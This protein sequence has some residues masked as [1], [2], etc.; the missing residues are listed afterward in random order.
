MHVVVVNVH[1]KPEAVDAFIAATADNHSHTRKEPANLRFDLL[2][3]N[4]D[5]NRFVLYEAYLDEQAFAT[6]Q[7]TA[8]YA[9]W[10]EA[11]TP[12][13]A[14]PRSAQK[15]TSLFPEPWQ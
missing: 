15:C 14:E 2:R 8:H 3:R 13:M 5:P 10:K 12:M 7:Q 4:D 11:V 6:H 9:R 1:V